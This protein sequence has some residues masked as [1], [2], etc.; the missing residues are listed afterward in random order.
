MTATDP[1]AA[2]HARIVASPEAPPSL[3]ALSRVAG[4]S[5]SQLTRRFRERYGVTPKE[6]AQS[7]R[8]QGLKRALR[9]GR[10]VT[11]A[12][13]D[14]GYGSPSRVYE[15]IDRH[16]GMTPGTYRRGGEG[17]AVRYT[18]ADTPLGPLLVATTGRGLCAVTLGASATALTRALATEFPR[19]ALS[20]VDEGADPWITGVV[21]RVAAALEGRRSAAATALPADLRASAFQWQVWRELM[22]IPPGETRSYGEVAAALGRPRAARAVARACASN[23]LAIVVPCHRVVREDGTLGGY[24]WGIDAKRRLLERE[25][26][27]V[28]AQGTA[29]R[30][31]GS[32]PRAQPKESAAPRR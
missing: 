1:L 30:A 25:R 27:A 14:A 10:E 16:L 22:R 2:A 20:R 18:I 23:R 28:R 3:K 32:G 15:A 31:Q 4:L 21:A 9:D 17:V 7:L 12:I 5:S 24:R 29:V 11:D 6:L 13:Y 26:A 8:L 19:A